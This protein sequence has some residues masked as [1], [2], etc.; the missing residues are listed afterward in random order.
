MNRENVGRVGGGGQRGVGRESGG[1]V[2]ELLG[3]WVGVIGDW[4]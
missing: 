4:G 1:R 2:R 3:L